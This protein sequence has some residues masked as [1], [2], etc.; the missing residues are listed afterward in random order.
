MQTRCIFTT[1]HDVTLFP[2]E[3]AMARQLSGAA[4]AAAGPRP[5]ARGQGGARPRSRRAGGRP[6]RNLALDRLVLHLMAGGRHPWRLYEALLGHGIGLVA[7]EPG[8]NGSLWPIASQCAASA[9]RMSEAL[10]PP[11]RTGFQRLSP[12]A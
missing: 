3:L 1:A 6:F 8:G 7:R 4:L 9:S 10:L 5:A 2:I 12:A 11:T